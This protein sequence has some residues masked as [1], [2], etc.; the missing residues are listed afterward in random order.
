MLHRFGPF[1]FFFFSYLGSE[2][3]LKFRGR[4]ENIWNLWGRTY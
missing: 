3:N 1:S 2:G 4:E